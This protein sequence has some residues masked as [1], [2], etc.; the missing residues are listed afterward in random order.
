[1]PSSTESLIGCGMPPEM[2]IRVGVTV[3]TIT[4]TSAAQGSAGGLLIG[5]GDKAVNVNVATGGHAVTLPSGAD[6]GTE[7]ELY[8][9]SAANAGIVFP[10]VGGFINGGAQNASLALGVQAAS[11]AAAGLKFRRI[12]VSTWK[13]LA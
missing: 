4:T 10:H 12:S 6:I 5:P 1:M 13:S 2:A 8:N 11:T 7:V 9:T 3:L